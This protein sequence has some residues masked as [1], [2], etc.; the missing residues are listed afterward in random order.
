MMIESLV[1]SDGRD[2]WRI[3]YFARVS[4]FPDRLRLS[5]HYMILFD[6]MISLSS[7]FHFFWYF[8]LSFIPSWVRFTSSFRC[9]ARY[10]VMIIILVNKIYLVLFS[11]YSTRTSTEVNSADMRW[12]SMLILFLMSIYLTFISIICRFIVLCVLPFFTSR[13]SYTE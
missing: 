8:S 3:I 12:S 7:S 6:L 9:N 10:I 13:C 4:L 1:D 11:I 5:I 2:I